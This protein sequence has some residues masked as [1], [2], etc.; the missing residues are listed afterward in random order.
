MGRSLHVPAEGG[1][2]VAGDVPDAG[3]LE[4]LV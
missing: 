1:A 4:D 2:D 3:A